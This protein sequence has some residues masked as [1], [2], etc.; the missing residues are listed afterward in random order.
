MDKFDFSAPADLFRHGPRG[1]GGTYYR[2]FETAAAAIS[3]AVEG[4]GENEARATVVQ[5]DDE[6]LDRQAI[7]ALYESSAY[8]LAR[9]PR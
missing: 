2:R 7:L 3:Y 6:R 4:L 9:K 5:V 8:P 1:R